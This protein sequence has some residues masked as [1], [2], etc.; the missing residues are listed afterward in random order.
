MESLKKLSALVAAG[1]LAF[2]LTGTATAD[3]VWATVT[4]HMASTSENNAAEWW[5][6]SGYDNCFKWNAGQGD[7]GV[8][9][10]T[11]VLGASYA[12]VVVK[13][14]SSAGDDPNSLTL[15]ANA[16]A[17][18]TVWADSNG[19]NAFDE[20]DK[21]ISHMIFCD[22]QETTTT[23]TEETTT[24]TT[25][26]E[27]TTTTTTEETTTTTTF[28]QETSG[29]TDTPTLPPTTMVGD[30]PSGPSQGSWLLVAALGAFLAGA[31]ILTP[32]RAKNRR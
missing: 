24:T 32:S 30:G 18:E 15:F 26:E 14:G 13:A 22:E 20:G 2:A 23:T 3:P 28:T 25:T 21:N 9:Q 11:Y 12:L 1:A 17:G 4:G 19:S 16:S 6:S 31:V 29:E 7:L 5:E 27:T 8:D 10:A